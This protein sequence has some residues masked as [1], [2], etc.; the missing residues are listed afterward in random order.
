MTRTTEARPQTLTFEEFLARYRDEDLWAEWVH[1][2]VLVMSPA[3]AR[4]Q[5]LADFLTALLRA[6]VEF[7]RLG[8]VLSAPFLMRLTR[9]IARE[10]DILFL[11]KEHL[12]RLKETYLDGPA[13][14][15]VEIVSSES[16]LRDRGEKFAEY[17][18]AGVPEYWLIDPELQR[19]DFYVLAPDGRY[20]HRRADAQGYYTA[21]VV[22]G[23][24]L[25][26]PWLWQDPLPPILEV[27]RAIGLM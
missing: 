5:M 15:V 11:R 22:S 12:G 18:M 26:V 23:F 24:R 4:H 6:F 2:E 20:E 13:D 8:V 3:S 10:P 25:Y 19:A 14:L 21:A 9:E 27:L 7:H 16:R 1:G 17:E